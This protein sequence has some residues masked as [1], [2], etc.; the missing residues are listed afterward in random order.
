[1]KNSAKQ[2]LET[3]DMSQAK[4]SDDL[5]DGGYFNPFG[6]IRSSK[7]KDAQFIIR[8]T[9]TSNKNELVLWFYNGQQLWSVVEKEISTLQETTN[10]ALRELCTRYDAHP[11]GLTDKPEP[12][13]PAEAVE[14]AEG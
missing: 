1:M 2:W 6:G 5:S 9:K 4:A 10:D 13:E 12:A 3:L 8:F 7:G 14:A 11:S